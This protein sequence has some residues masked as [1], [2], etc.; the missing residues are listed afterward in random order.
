MGAVVCWM[1]SLARA[2]VGS[3]GRSLHWCGTF[4]PNVMWNA[5]ERPEL[6]LFKDGFLSLGIGDLR[7]SL[8]ESRGAPS[9]SSPP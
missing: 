6:I 1:E 4:L 5:L 9:L 2:R 7:L 8:L 3:H